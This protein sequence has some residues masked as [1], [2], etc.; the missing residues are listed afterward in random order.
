M[1][2][3]I[4]PAN[5]TANLLLIMPLP[6]QLSVEQ[7]QTVSKLSGS[8]SGS[9]NIPIH[10]AGNFQVPK[11]HSSFFKPIIS[12]AALFWTKQLLH[13]VPLEIAFTQAGSTFISPCKLCVYSWDIVGVKVVSPFH[14][15]YHTTLQK[16]ITQWTFLGHCRTEKNLQSAIYCFWNQILSALPIWMHQ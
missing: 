2:A 7:R 15:V 9:L 8:F 12:N 5:Q 10:W 13:V 14:H 3:A 11:L 16:R 1:Y 6:L 4:V